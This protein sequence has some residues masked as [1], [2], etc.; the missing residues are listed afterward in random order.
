[1]QFDAIIFD[2]GNTLVP[3]GPEQG[4]ALYDAARRVLEAE[5]GPIE[6]FFTKARNAHMG[7][8]REREDGS[9]REVTCAEFVA[10][11]MG[12]EQPAD[13]VEKVESESHR[14][15]VELCTVPPHVRPLLE[16]LRERYRLGVLSNFFLHGTVE[17]VLQTGGLWEL[18]EHVEVSST[19]GWMKPH[20]APFEAV[21]MALGS[22]MERTLMVGDDFFA[23]VV[24]G[25]RAGLLTALTHEY[26]QAD[27]FDARAP[28]VKADR[29]LSSLDELA[30]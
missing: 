17:E 22:E 19:E 12:A 24:G 30:R 27:P 14:T 9:M 7:L 11:I 20:P 23:D 8:V 29:I 25:F 18:F 21:R 16:R 6:D 4:R 26:R 13:L 3:W 28:E 2:F 10:A 5:A 1:M 15:F